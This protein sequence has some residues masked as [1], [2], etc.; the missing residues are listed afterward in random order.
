MVFILIIEVIFHSVSKN[1]IK[2]YTKYFNFVYFFQ[3]HSYWPHFYGRMIAQYLGQTYQ[4]EGKK[5]AFL[6]NSNLASNCHVL[7]HSCERKHTHT[8]T[9]KYERK[10][11]A[12]NYVTILRESERLWEWGLF[13]SIDFQFR[14]SKT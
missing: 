6:I 4:I 7:S 5:L 2:K 3:S 10:K 13:I 1:R 14:F 9:H 8:H 12:K 11:F